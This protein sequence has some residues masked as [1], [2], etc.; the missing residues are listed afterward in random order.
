MGDAH[1]LPVSGV[2][3]QQAVA[4]EFQETL[5]LLRS[6]LPRTPSIPLH[7]LVDPKRNKRTDIVITQRN[8]PR[9]FF[10]DGLIEGRRLR[11]RP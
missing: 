6:G 11:R 4:P 7:E 2:V 9:G 8:T 5:S 10:G 3:H 1:G